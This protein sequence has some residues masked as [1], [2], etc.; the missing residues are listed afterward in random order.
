MTTFIL[1]R[2][3]LGSAD[4][5]EFSGKSNFIGDVDLAAKDLLKIIVMGS[6][7]PTTIPHWLS[8]VL[9][10][11]N[12]TKANLK[13]TKYKSLSLV[14][15]GFGDIEF[16]K[17]LKNS[18]ILKENKSTF[19]SPENY[20]KGLWKRVYDQRN[21]GSNKYTSLMNSTPKT[22]EDKL[23]F[24]K[25]KYVAY[26]VSGQL[27]ENSNWYD[28]YNIH[29]PIDF[30]KS[31]LDGKTNDQ[32]KKIMKDIIKSVFSGDENEEEINKYLE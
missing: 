11:I 25:L 17:K 6:K 31:V 10:A 29:S 9:G 12:K 19:D 16:K 2:I 26:R 27:G 18:G 24:D 22:D 1:K 5:K 30:S 13:T 20:F 32:I 4:Q 8:E 23:A 3:T 15:Y 28:V 14:F 21:N 7:T